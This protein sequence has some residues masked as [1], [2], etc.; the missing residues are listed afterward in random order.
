[1]GIR[2]ILLKPLF[3]YLNNCEY[4]WP[5]NGVDN[6]MRSNTDIRPDKFYRHQHELLAVDTDGANK[7]SADRTYY[8]SN[9]EYFDAFRAPSQT[10]KE[11]LPH[12]IFLRLTKETF[13]RILKLGYT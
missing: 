5:S 10:L 8:Y 2:T 1:M 6:W 3:K 9:N 11:V 7:I 4:F 12:D 13:D